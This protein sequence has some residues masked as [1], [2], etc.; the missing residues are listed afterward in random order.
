MPIAKLKIEKRLRRHKK[1]R[2]RV[3]GTAAVPRLAAFRSNKYTYGALIDD[4]TGK[5]ILS[6]SSLKI[7]AANKVA[8]ARETGKVIATQALAKKIS[9]AVFDRGGYIYTGRVKALADGAREGG[10]KL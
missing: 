10:L 3:S 1:V 2:S 5:T 6:A 7:K 4:T 8:A 9:K